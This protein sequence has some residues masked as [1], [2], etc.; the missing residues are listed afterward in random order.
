MEKNIPVCVYLCFVLRH[1]YTLLQGIDSLPFLPFIAHIQRNSE[2]A[3]ALENV[4][5]V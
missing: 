4:Q 2:H 1:M 5:C 3:Y